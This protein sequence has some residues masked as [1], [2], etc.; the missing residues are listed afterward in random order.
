MAMDAIRTTVVFD[1]APV[2]RDCAQCDCTLSQLF[3]PMRRH[4]LII[5]TS[6]LVTASYLFNILAARSSLRLEPG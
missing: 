4:W 6:D 5:A 3:H 1:L 2:P